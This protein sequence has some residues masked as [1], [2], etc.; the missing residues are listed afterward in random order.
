MQREWKR[1]ARC[2]K[3]TG[4]LPKASGSSSLHS[5]GKYLSAQHKKHLPPKGVHMPDTAQEALTRKAEGCFGLLGCLL[6]FL[7][8]FFEMSSPD[9]ID[10]A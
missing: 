1:E 5:L 7:G 10:A 6:G 3:G 4:T 2:R 9:A 8:G